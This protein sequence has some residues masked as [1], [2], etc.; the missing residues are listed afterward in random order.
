M[1]GELKRNFQALGR[2]ETP[3]YYM[4]YTIDSIKRQS[5][6]AS[7]GALAK[8][9]ETSRAYLTIDVRV[10]SPK[11]DNTHEIR[12]GRRMIGLHEPNKA[13]L[14]EN[15]QGLKEL[16]WQETD[17]A[18][19]EAVENL[20]KVKTDKALKVKEEDESS[21]FTLQSPSV[22]VA[23]P[24]GVKVDLDA[25]A[26][27]VRAYSEPF[28][29]LPYVLKGDA[30]FSSE[31]RTKYFVNTEG[32]R[33]E[34]TVN[35]MRLFISATAKAD[36]GMELPLMLSYFGFRESDFPGEKQIEAH[37]TAMVKTLGLLR[38]APL[39]E[40]YEGPAILS[41]KSSGVFF[42][43]ILGHR[44]EGH[45]QKSESES[46]TFK[47][48]VHE[49]ILPEFISVI[50]D[51]TVKELGALKLSGFYEYDDQGTKAEKVV[52]VKDG[53]LRDFLM[54]RSPIEGFPRSN[55]HA[56]CQPGQVPVSRQSNLIVTSR[57]HYPEKELKEMLIS[58]LKKQ[59]K[60]FGLYFKEIQG[61][62]TLTTRS[63]P[64]AFT[65]NPLVVYKIFVDGRPDE[66][67]RGVNFIGTP[68]TTFDK[69]IATGD[70]PEVFN[71]MCGAESGDVPVSAVSPSLL[72][73]QIEVQKKGK[74]QDK[75][76][77]LPPPPSQIEERGSSR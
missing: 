60:P 3:P 73:R 7:F 27:K 24:A 68:L 36:D 41:G 69:I 65:V 50:F 18:Y 67:V 21:D 47:K 71:G 42:H 13:P 46:Q 61:G 56:R 55:G 31:V 44:L 8:K 30:S 64:N 5:A 9:L 6:Y 39:V 72:V 12:G 51:P 54:T 22:S 49:K 4:S 53:V 76:P 26:Q 43:E 1:E 10:G 17:D 19:R 52:A 16:L 77:I 35:Y 32:S 37:I 23:E 14:D 2:Q 74:S 62:F 34:T 40:A 63:L 75:L 57:K 45:R 58:E 70:T 11:V 59:G 33:V 25:W 15:P 38:M 28:R 66:L 48:K 20:A 29:K